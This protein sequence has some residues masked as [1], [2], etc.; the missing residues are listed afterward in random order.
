MFSKKDIDVLTSPII[1]T[2]EYNENVVE[3]LI[4]N[5]KKLVVIITDVHKYTQKNDYIKAQRELLRFASELTRHV[6][7][8]QYKVYDYLENV[9]EPK[10]ELLKTVVEFRKVMRK[11]QKE[12]RLFL[13]C[14]VAK[15]IEGNP[16]AF[17]EDLEINTLRLASRLKH[18]EEML[19]PMYEDCRDAAA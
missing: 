15:G 10:S 13:A 1:M 2:R 4:N 14:W 5:H 8:V 16:D 12:L 19:Y 9:L 6:T 3:E 18:E 7:K 17:I 11:V